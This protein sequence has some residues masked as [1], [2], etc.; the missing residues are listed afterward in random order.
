[1]IASRVTNGETFT[2]ERLTHRKTGSVIINTFMPQN[3]QNN[4]ISAQLPE[5]I[6]D[7]NPDV[8][9]MYPTINIGIVIAARRV[10]LHFTGLRMR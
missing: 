7:M 1:M 2:C 3:D 8:V 6:I 4:S 9:A 10:L 5:G